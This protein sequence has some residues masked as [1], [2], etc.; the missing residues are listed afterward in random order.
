MS[1]PVLFVSHGAPTLPLEPGAT[2]VATTRRAV[3]EAIRHSG[4]L[5]ALEN[6]YPDSQPRCSTGNH[7]RLQRLSGR[8]L[9]VELSRTRRT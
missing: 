4:D 5:G 8:T 9:Q 2:G 6:A 7:P 1:M 3:A